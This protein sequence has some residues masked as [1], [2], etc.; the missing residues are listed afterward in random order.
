[1]KVRAWPFLL[2]TACMASVCSLAEKKDWSTWTA[3]GADDTVQYHWQLETWGRNMS[4]SCNLEIRNV[5]T[6]IDAVK[7]KFDIKRSQKTETL[8]RIYYMGDEK[9]QVASDVFSDCQEISGLTVERKTVH[10]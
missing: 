3:A 5:F 6:R 4:P 2:L 9:K 8:H 10:K 1:M 7:V